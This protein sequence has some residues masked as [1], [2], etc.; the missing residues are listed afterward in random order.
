M[1][2]KGP[3]KEGSLRVVHLGG[4]THVVTWAD[5]SKGVQAAKPRQCV[6]LGGGD[7]FLKQVGVDASTRQR[8]A[9]DLRNHK[10]ST[11]GIVRLTEDELKRLG[12]V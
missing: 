1:V 3:Q 12:L 10:S 9:T 2:G 11:V 7:D 5:N 8:V 6:G 4:E